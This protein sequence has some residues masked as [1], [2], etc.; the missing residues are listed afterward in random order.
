MPWFETALA[1]LAPGWAA[2]R[3]AHRAQLEMAKRA[4]EAAKVGRRTDGWRATGASANAEI[5]Q[6]AARLRWRARELARNN[7]HAV[8]A[9]NNLADKVV[10]AGIVPRLD[11]KAE[12]TRLKQQ[13][14]DWWNAFVDSC[15][16]DGQL[17]FYGFTH[18][19]ARAMFES[20]EVLI[21]LLPRPSSLGLKVP[22]QIELLEP[23]YLDSSKTQRQEDGG[24]V[25]Q[26]VEFD[27]WGRRVAY[28]LFDDHPGSDS[29]WAASRTSRRWPAGQILHVF[30]PLRPGQAR[31]VSAFAASA[32]RLHRLDD[33]A[34]AELERKRIAAC[35]AAFVKHAGGP[36][37]GVLGG[38]RQGENAV[39]DTDG[40][41]VQS[42]S[43]GMI[44]HLGAGADVEFSNPPASEGYSEYWVAEL[45]AAAAGIGVTY[46]QMT[47]DLSQ[48]NYSSAR[49]GLVN[50]WGRVDHWQA[51]IAIPQLC[52]RIWRPVMNLGIALGKLPAGVPLAAKWT[53]PKRQ[54]VDPAKEIEAKNEE[55]R[56]GLTTLAEAIAECGWDP[57]AHLEEI[58][59]TNARLDELGIVLDCD[60]RRVG[61]ASASAPATAST[62]TKE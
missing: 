48:V 23:D 47:G 7:V 33:F 62:P 22:L 53:P 50:F 14:G 29:P 6:G 52:Q 27:R 15:T 54:W 37:P 25:I 46:E 20:G 17:D 35:L 4:Y 56:S 21:R 5:A 9:L 41:P 2:R 57:D 61:R 51:H 43:P 19:A 13:A 24:A 38:D 58:A 31:G 49:V 59:R 36:N 12:E 18:L 30:D 44:F 55:I 40:K 1:G 34:D 28:W 8:S 60:P 32:L 10:G 42:I 3:L 11:V 26:G 45:R 16:P 39:T